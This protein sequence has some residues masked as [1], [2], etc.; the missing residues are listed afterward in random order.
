MNYRA[1]FGVVVFA[2]GLA[3]LEARDQ[4]EDSA[5]EPAVIEGKP[6]TM[7]ASQ[8]QRTIMDFSDRYISALWIALDG[9]IQ[10]EPDVSKQVKAQ[11]WKVMLG[12]TAMTIAASRDPRSGLLDMAVFISAG[13]WAANRYWIPEVFGPKAEA[14]RTVYAE[15][16]QEIWDEVKRVLTPAQV[17]DL[18]RLIQDWIATNPSRVEV[19]DVRLRNLD[20][21]VLKNFSEAP[22]ARGLLASV[23]RLWGSV[24]QS[25]LYGERVIFY[26]ERMPRILALQSD[27]T[28]DRVAERFPIATI[29]PDFSNLPEL[30]KDWPERI[31]QAISKREAFVSENLPDLRA[32]LESFERTTL[33]LQQSLASIQELSGRIEKLPFNPDEYAVGYERLSASLGQTQQIVDGLNRLV[34]STLAPDGRPRAA[35]WIEAA[36]QKAQEW[37]DAAFYRALILLAAFFVGALVLLVVARTLFFRRPAN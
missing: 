18:R 31:E 17:A 13:K 11:R 37:L 30:G 22:S 23:R 2:I 29:N 1:V 3:S 20:G 16:D 35:Q 25:M 10:N 32:S 5:D 12:S 27:L 33:S 6:Q 21:V 15:M 14:L 8:L 36:D 7:S 4:P 28:I 26:M 34:D 9:Y 19:L 24:D